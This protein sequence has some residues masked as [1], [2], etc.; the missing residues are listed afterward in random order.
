MDDRGDSLYRGVEA[1]PGAEV[2]HDGPGI[3][4]GGRAEKPDGVP[5]GGE[6]RND[7]A[8]EQAGAAGDQ[9]GGHGAVP[10]A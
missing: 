7:R 8:A 3:G 6:L 4:G 5:G 1:G 2:N 10:L 9:D